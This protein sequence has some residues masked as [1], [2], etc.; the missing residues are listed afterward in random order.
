MATDTPV[1]F[2]EDS[3]AL[4]DVDQNAVCTTEHGNLAIFSV[5]AMAEIWATKTAR[6]IIVVPVRIARGGH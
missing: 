1:T 6:N 5:R 2:R 3:N 4:F